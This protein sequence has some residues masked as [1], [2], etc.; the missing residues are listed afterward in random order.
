VQNHGSFVFERVFKTTISSKGTSL[1]ELANAK[2]SLV[3]KEEE[4]RQLVKRMQRLE[5]TQERLARERRRGPRC[6]TMYH[7][8]YRNEEEEEEEEEEW[9]VQNVETRHHQHQ[10]QPP[11]P[12]FPFVKLPSFSGKSHPN[13]YSRWEGKVEQMCMR[14]KRTKRLS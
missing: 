7:M 11:K 10:P 6:T 12:Y 14:S 3:H 9:R 5:D 4:I 8:H 2:T 13:L 1:G